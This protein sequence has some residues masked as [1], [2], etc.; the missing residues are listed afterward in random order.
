[1]G[2]RDFAEARFNPLGS[3]PISGGPAWIDTERFQIDAKSD[4][5]QKNGIMNGPMLRALLE[6]R[7]HLIIRRETRL[8]PVYVITVARRQM[9]HLQRASSN[10]IAFD[11]EHPP[12]FE[13]GKPFPIV[14]GMARNT[15][16]GYD[17]FGVTITVS[18]N[19]FRTSGSKGY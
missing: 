8:A 12:V 11:P 19:S 3:I 15:G 13:P 17:A 9:P 6:D 1:M 16:Q 2:L 5:P 4:V 14:C 10:C 7:F 18:R